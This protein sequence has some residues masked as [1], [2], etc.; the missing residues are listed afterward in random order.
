[1]VQDL[2][3]DCLLGKSDIKS[4]FRLLPVSV[5]DFD[6]LGFKFDG[7]FY[8]DKAMPFGCSIACQ[9]WELYSTFLEFYVARQSSVRKLHH[10][11]DD[12]LF[13]GKKGKMTLL[14]VPIA[15]E[16]TEGPTTKICFL[17]LEIDSEQMVV[18]IPMPKIKEIIQKI[19][20]LLAHAKCTLKQMQSLIG[21]LNFA[22]RAI[23]QGRP[24]CR[25][26]I[27]ATCGLT[28]QHHHLRITTDMRKDLDLWLQFFRDFNGIS[29]FHD[30]FWVS[31]EDMQLFTDSAWVTGFGAYFAGKWAYGSWP[32]SWVVQGIIDDITVLELFPY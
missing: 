10:Y 22:C 30:R 7:K 31:N 11:L 6:Q 18:R 16:K 5:L 26:L 20:D 19:E 3:R 15:H 25:R 21:S 32:Q 8:F 4:A 29:V 13:G 17:G 1:M 9:C 23:T 14:G 27:N 24:F 12:F 28:K 2:G